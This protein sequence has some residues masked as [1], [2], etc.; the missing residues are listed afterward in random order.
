M[1]RNKRSVQRELHYGDTPRSTSKSRT[2]EESSLTKEYSTN[3]GTYGD[4]RHIRPI[5]P[6]PSSRTSTLSKQ[7]KVNNVHQYPMEI[8]ET[9]TPDINPE[10][11][12]NLDPTLHPPG[13][14]KVTTTIKTYTYEIP[15][16]GNFPTNLDH[17]PDTTIE[18]YVY[19]PNQTQTTPSKSF[20]YKKYENE[21][22]EESVNYPADSSWENRVLRETTTDNYLP[23][24]KPAPPGGLNVVKE[25]VTTRNY[26]PGYSPVNVPTSNQT[27]IY[28]ET[29]TSRNYDSLPSNPP[30]QDT[31]I[32]EVHDRNVTNTREYAPPP[33]KQ[34]IKEFNEMSTTVNSYPPVEP[35]NKTVFYKHEEHTT[36]NFGPGYKHPNDVE[37][38]VPKPQE[39]LN[40]Q[41]KYKSESSTRNNYKTGYPPTNESQVLLPK[42]FPKNENEPDGPPKKLDD[43]MATI[44]NEPPTSPYNAGF[45]VHEKEVEQMKKIETL[46]RQQEDMDQKK[47][48]IQRSKNVSGPA[49][50]YPPGHEMFAKK[51][52]GGAWR[53]Q[54]G[55]EKAAGKYEYEA[56]S[57]SKSKQSS[58]KA[59]VPVCLPLCCGLP[60]TII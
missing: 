15:G 56:E 6:A 32:K 18:K 17:N 13:N 55:Y 50:Y 49:V 3:E 48:P 43:L 39:P 22:H 2:Y 59:I 12:A 1:H 28:N 54:G 16:S 36:E 5:S 58:G 38:F 44:G 33:V 11:L 23:Y 45:I 34:Y 30:R 9:T 4:L 8:V 52:E 37:T 27:Y 25:T 10:I 35:V 40:I 19:S 60:C 42:P 20:V 24:K 46:K 29:T 57:K 14:T 53:A 47:E 26:Q 41:Y 7:T 51:E 31:Y 21:H